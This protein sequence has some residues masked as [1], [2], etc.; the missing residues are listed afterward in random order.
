MHAPAG[1]ETATFSLVNNSANQGGGISLEQ[2]SAIFL[3]PPVNLHFQNNNATVG[4]AIFVRDVFTLS[5]CSTEPGTME[6][7][8]D[9]T[10]LK[11]VG[12]DALDKQD[13]DCNCN[14][15]FCF[16]QL[17]EF[18]ST[19]NTE[20][21]FINNSA[22]VAG[23]VLYGG[24]LES[25]QFTTGFQNEGSPLEVFMN[26]STITDNDPSSIISSDSTGI[27]FRFNDA[28][29]CDAYNVSISP[30]QKFVLSA[31]AVGQARGTVPTVIRSYFISGEAIGETQR[32]QETGKEF[33][34]LEYRVFS[35]KDSEQLIL[36]PEGPCRD[37]GTAR[38]SVTVHLQP[39][40][41]G[42]QL[43]NSQ[44]IC[45]ERLQTFTNSCNIDD[46][47]ILRSS[48]FWMSGLY[49]NGS[50]QGLILHPRCPFD[51]CLTTVLSLTPSDPN[52]QCASDRTGTLCGSCPKNFSV[53][54]GSSR[55]L[56]CRNTYLSLLIPFAMA[57]IVLV[58]FLLALKLTVSVGTINGLIFYANVVSVNRAIFFPPGAN[59]ILTVFIAWVNLDLG[60]ETCFYNGMDAYA[61]TWLQ[62]VFPFYLWLLTAMIILASHCSLRL[63]KYLGTNPVSVLATLF[64]LSYAKLLRT[65]ISAFRNTF[66]E[67]PDGSQV[68]VWL[69]D[70]NIRYL[71]CKHIPLFL[72]AL[73]TLLFLFLPYT[74]FLLLG[75]WMLSWSDKKVLSWVNKPTVKTLLD[76]YY[77]PYQDKH[78]Y[79]TGLLLLLRG[80]M[81]VTFAFNILG[82]PSV[83]LLCITSASLGITMVTRMTGQIYKKLWLDVLE[84]SFILNLGVLAA[85]TYHVRLA[86]GCQ[87][88]LSYLSVSIALVTFIGILLYHIY[89][90]THSATFWK[91]LPKPN[92]QIC[93]VLTPSDNNGHNPIRN[94]TET[95]PN[96]HTASDRELVSTT[97]VE[98]REPL[99]EDAPRK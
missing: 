53:A 71:S 64:L 67:Y 70:G 75:Q 68:S 19:E 90:Q 88:V 5:E 28:M 80:V 76:T 35:P 34:N 93:W 33:T 6:Q 57:G 37:L 83:N 2:N 40:P 14:G 62:F 61:R 98:F 7:H 95:E 91:R 17:A 82:D 10:L 49:M 11:E 9:P 85:A 54:F 46:E 84:A 4:G 92:F 24:K 25:C 45:G 99:L 65:I 1:N 66:L 26:L 78:R 69:L 22:S 97:Y 15:N 72:A 42:F 60:I 23:S 43:S 13:S 29:L 16:L 48:N 36:Y 89:L 27:C 73:A 18:I 44:C 81:F 32:I 63:S 55:C 52:A 86:G 3:Y 50:Y 47:T 30:G 94:E 39:C 31:V 21:V 77:G 58:V 12:E 56:Q 79:W 38:R 59:N 87:G 74:L 41:D 51:Y 96:P 20:L 8:V